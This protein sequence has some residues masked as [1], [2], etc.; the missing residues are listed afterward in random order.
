MNVGECLGGVGIEEN[1]TG[2]QIDAFL[3]HAK[4]NAKEGM[5][6]FEGDDGL[7]WMR[8]LPVPVNHTSSSLRT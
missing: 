8:N 1:D 5:E 4:D 2:V 6:R 3:F 7:E